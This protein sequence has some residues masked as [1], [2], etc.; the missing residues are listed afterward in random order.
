[1]VKFLIRMARDPL[2]CLSFLDVCTDGG[3][4]SGP[5]DTTRHPEAA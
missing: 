4:P 5:S 3:C 2:L 1:M